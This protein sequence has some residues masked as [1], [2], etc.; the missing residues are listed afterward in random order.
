MVGVVILNYNNTAD[1][2]NCI[3]SL[4]AFEQMRNIKLLIVDNGSDYN[5]QREAQAYLNQKFGCYTLVEEDG[6]VASLSNVNYLQLPINVGY[7]QGNNAG[8][9]AFLRDEHISY[10]MFL[11]SDVVFTQSVIPSLVDVIKRKEGCGAI[12]PLL[13][14]IN[15][16][17]DH[18]CARL[19]YDNV[20][21]AITFS[22]LFANR[23]KKRINNKKILLQ[24]PDLLKSDLVEIE[25]PSGSCMLFDKKVIEEIGGF[26]SHTFLYYEESILFEKLKQRGR[27]SYLMPSVSC[28]HVGGATT[29]TT[30]T[31]YFLKLCNYNSLLYYVKNY[32]CLTKASLYYIIITGR[33]RLL[34]LY[35]AMKLKSKL[36]STCL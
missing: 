10:I 16:T 27:K 12:S 20:D 30:K 33:L 36:K 35:I 31:A 26:D 14:R 5:V 13:Y 15:G 19:N 32:R 17:V 7:A 29:T 6:A 4:T 24:N 2:T 9:K 25:L 8:I 34:R 28:I 18:C 22:Y 3:E 23:N 1:L 21:L 11:N